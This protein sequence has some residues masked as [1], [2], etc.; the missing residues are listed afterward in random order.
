MTTPISEPKAKASVPGGCLIAFG[1][2]FVLAGLAI[3]GAIL[4]LPTLT[5]LSAQNWPSTDCTITSA[6]IESHRGDGSTTYE[7]KFTYAYSVG[8]RQYTGS[9]DRIQKWSGNRST[10]RARL[11]ELPVGTRTTCWYDPIDPS[12]SLLDRSFSIGFALIGVLFVTMFTGMGGL[13]VYLGFRSRADAKRPLPRSITGAIKRP[14][15]TTRSERSRSEPSTAS[16]NPLDAALAGPQ[17]LTPSQSRWKRFVFVLIFTLFWNGI[18]FLVAGGFWNGPPFQ[19]GWA[20]IG[21]G[22]FFVPFFV[23]GVVMIFSTIVSLLSLFAPQ[24]SVALSNGA[25]ARGE[26]LDVAW[27]IT[28]GVRPVHRLHVCVVA[29][30]WAQYLQGTDLKTDTSAF[31]VIPVVTAEDGDEIRFGTRPITI[32][33]DTMHSLDADHNQIRWTIRVRGDVR[34]FPDVDEEFT[35]RVTPDDVSMLDSSRL[36]TGSTS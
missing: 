20:Q 3:G 32:P 11:N 33:V 16:T 10:A 26:T 7:A 9:R 30:E 22:L 2:I 35:F 21:M 15:A 36:P 6:E 4:V 29:I 18:V 1:G 25:V 27:E 24:V 5:Y 12:K 8:D 17:R 19:N 14:S 13:V 34:W 31:E 23:I 28:G